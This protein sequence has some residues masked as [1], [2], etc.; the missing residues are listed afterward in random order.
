M[1]SRYAVLLNTRD[2]EPEMVTRPVCQ[3]DDV[4]E[5]QATAR[6]LNAD[7]P[8]AYYSILDRDT[9]QYL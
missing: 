7:D 8:D 3:T 5:A 1:K 2:G 9:D 6:E 4:L